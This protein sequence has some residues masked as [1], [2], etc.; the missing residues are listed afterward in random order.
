MDRRHRII[1]ITIVESLATVLLERGIYFYT[2]DLMGFG[3]AA[4]LWLALVFGVCYVGGAMVSHAV[5]HHCGERRTMVAVI[6]ALLVIQLAVAAWPTWAALVVG[7]P[8]VGLLSGLKWPIIESYVAAGQTPA[9]TLRIVGRFNC[10]W[11]IGVPVGVSMSGWFIGSPAPW[12]LFLAVAVMH[13]VTLWMTRRV[14]ARPMH[15]PLDHPE[16]PDA[17]RLVR[18]RAMLASSRWTM[19]ASSALLLLLAPL[20]PTILAP[21][22][23]SVKAATGWA[24]LMDWLRVGTFALLWVWT[25][26]YGRAWPLLASIVALSAGFFL[27]LFG[28]NLAT[29]AAG[30]VLFGVAAGVTYYAAL[31]YALVVKNA[32]VDAGGVHEALIGAGFAIGPL[33]GLAG[34]GLAGPMGGAVPGMVAAT[35]PVVLLLTAGALW[36]LKPLWR[37]GHNRPATLP[38]A[39]LNR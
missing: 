29:V 20:L 3:D 8:I 19:L 39:S 32:A 23:G 16:R 27:V 7:F 12:T 13:A 30:E 14:A 38:D 1:L 2:H 22:T 10:A 6:A 11:A 36:S 31:Y 33:M 21:L 24:A 5:A 34:L 28:G 25:G 17:A 35:V 9:N 15:L 37:A 26:W 4:N 18:Y